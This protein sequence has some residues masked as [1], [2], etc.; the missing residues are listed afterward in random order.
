DLPLWHTNLSAAF[1]NLLYRLIERRHRDRIYRAGT[2]SLAGTGQTAIDS[3]VLIVARGDEP[4]LNWPTLELF[5]LPAENIPVKR[6]H[7]FRILR[8]NFEVNYA[9][10][11][12]IRTNL[13]SLSKER[14][15]T[16]NISLSRTR[17]E[18]LPTEYVS[19]FTARLAVF[20]KIIGVSIA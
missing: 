7:C 20:V 19:L 14:R 12:S 4:V 10:H 8:I 3:R 1:F 5:E 13:S 9:L 11:I 16:I 15:G 2:L 17:D 18:A 6:L